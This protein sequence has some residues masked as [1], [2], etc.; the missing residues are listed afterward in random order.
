MPSKDRE[1]KNSKKLQ[2]AETKVAFCFGQETMR[3]G[4]RGHNVCTERVT[5]IFTNSY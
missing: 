4:K 1:K 3:W 2:K 5:Q